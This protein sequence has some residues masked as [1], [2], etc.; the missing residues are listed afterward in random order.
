MRDAVILGSSPNE[1]ALACYL[2]KA[3]K[4][5]TVIEPRHELGGTAALAE[6]VP[7]FRLEVA[8]PSLGWVSPK[9]VRDLGLE[10]HGFESAWT[11]ATVL[12]P[13][14]DGPPLVLWRDL[15]RSRAEI[16]KHSKADAEKWE[17]FATRMERLAGFLETLYTEAPP[18]L[19]SE[20]PGDLFSLMAVG[21][22]LRRLG[23]I[24][25]VELLR[26][27]PMSVSDL[28][29]DWFESDVLKAAI[30]AGGVTSLLQGPR[31]A[32]TCFVMLHHLVGRPLGAFRARTCVKGE[33]GHLIHALRAAAKQ[34]G[35][36]TKTGARATI[37]TKG[38][39]ATGVALASGEE[40][41]ARVVVSGADPRTTFRKLVDPTE[42]EPETQRAVGNVKLRGVRAVVNLALSELPR[43]SGV[44]GEEALG[45]V[46]STS[47][48]LDYLERAYDDAKHGGISRALHLEATIPSLT[49]PSLA[50]AGKHVMSVAVQWAPY[51][52]REGKWDGPTKEALADRVIATLAEHAPGFEKAVMGRAIYTPADLEE[53]FGLAEGHL[54][55][56]ELTLDQILF[57]RP[58]PGYAHYRAPLEGLFMC[59]DATHPGGG[60]PGLAGANAAREILAEIS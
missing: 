41:A 17:P 60:L 6:I 33:K 14:L 24:D 35:V 7:G 8:P 48:S 57:M 13:R 12:T 45:G 22:R 10:A 53:D 2:A 42:L 11:D 47:P 23:K 54:H 19:M 40:I 55:G 9:I 31:S 3:G 49:D 20:Q 59:G 30:G 43:F 39:C 32:G 58:L 16:A 21:L 27:L 36:E 29:D 1:I 50:P 25:M 5:V 4:K 46:I 15:E 38:G 51:H 34:L 28:L 37:M 44:S 52:L 56:G 26:T 18:R